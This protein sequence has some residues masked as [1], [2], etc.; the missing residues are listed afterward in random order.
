MGDPPPSDVTRLLAHVSAG[1]RQALE[2]L[3]PLVYR[4]L[5]RRA[6]GYLRRERPNHTLQPTALVN[7]AYMR[8]LEQQ[9]VRWQ[10]RSH[11]FAIAAQSMRRILVDHAR[12]HRRAKRNGGLNVTLDSAELPVAEISIDL[13]A[14]DEALERLASRDVQQAR[15]VE[16]RFFG[17]LSV[18]E[19]AELLGC[20]VSTVK[21]EWTMARVW[22][23]QQ[24]R[25][26]D[27]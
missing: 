11:F 4:E 3:F 23:H 20:S 26:E 19:I 8:L 5:R 22:L 10:N 13:L 1:D 9:H 18:E 15:V 17:G 6:A 21:R 24:L 7:D 14:L 27:P 16:M 2:R 25:R 12:R